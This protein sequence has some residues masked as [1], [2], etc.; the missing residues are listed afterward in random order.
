MVEASR[1]ESLVRVRTWSRRFVRGF[2]SL[3]L[4]GRSLGVVF[5]E[6]LSFLVVECGYPLFRYPTVA[7]EPLCE[8]GHSCRGSVSHELGS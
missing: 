2:G 6:G 8:C 3:Y 5:S 7:P 4:R 1:R